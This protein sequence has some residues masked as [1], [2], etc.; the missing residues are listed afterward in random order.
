MV[1]EWKICFYNWVIFV[2][3]VVYIVSVCISFFVY[4]WVKFWGVIYCIEN[5][6]EVVMI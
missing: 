1:F 5:V 6:F 4:F 3:S 2:S